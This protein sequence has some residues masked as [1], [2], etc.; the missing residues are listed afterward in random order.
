M[1][2]LKSVLISAGYSPMVL[3][4]RVKDTGI[5]YSEFKRKYLEAKYPG[6]GR[7]W[8]RVMQELDDMGV[9]W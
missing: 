3:Y 6:S 8:D 2:R 7:V 4:D 9:D 5:R 1:H